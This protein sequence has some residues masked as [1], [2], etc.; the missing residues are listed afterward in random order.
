M[1]EYLTDFFEWIKLD[2]EKKEEADLV[3]AFASGSSKLIKVKSE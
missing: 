3:L 2:Q 1:K